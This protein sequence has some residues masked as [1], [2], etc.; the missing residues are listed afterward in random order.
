MK[1]CSTI[2]SGLEHV[3]FLNTTLDGC[4]FGRVNAHEIRNL[5][6]AKITQGGATEG[7]VKH[8]RESILAA[9]RPQQGERRQT[10]AK[11]RGG[12]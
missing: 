2:D 5:H 11:K 7:E 4:S 6:T 1:S 12:R 10:P 3:S 9:L 8:N